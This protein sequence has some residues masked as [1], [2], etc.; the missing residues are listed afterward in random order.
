M[1]P[2]WLG[3]KEVPSDGNLFGKCFAIF[4]ELDVLSNQK[5]ATAPFAERIR[6]AV[7]LYFD[8]KEHDYPVNYISAKS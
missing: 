5:I 2:K 3:R 7:L 4:P 8:E 1:C 6:F